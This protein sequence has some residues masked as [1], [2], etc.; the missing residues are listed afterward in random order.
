MNMYEIYGNYFL[1][2]HREAL[3]QGSGRVS[4]HDNVFVDGPGSYPAVVLRDTEESA[5]SRSGL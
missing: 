4:L 2:N 3:F 5:E 1:H